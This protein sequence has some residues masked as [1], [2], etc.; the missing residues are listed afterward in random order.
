MLVLGS[1]YV[2][3]FTSPYPCINH[4]VCHLMTAQQVS[5]DGPHGR[6]PEARKK[7]MSEVVKSSFQ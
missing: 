5:V 2:E 3:E 1:L 7:Q 6:V 4:L